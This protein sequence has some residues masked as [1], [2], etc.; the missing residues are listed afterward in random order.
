MNTCF[1]VLIISP[2]M[3]YDH[4]LFLK[5][6]YSDIK[7]HCTELNGYFLFQWL[8]EET[9]FRYF[10]IYSFLFVISF[11]TKEL[12]INV[13]VHI[14]VFYVGHPSVSLFLSIHCTPY[15]RNCPSPDNNFWYTGRKQWYL[16][17]IFF[18]FIK[19]WFFGFLGSKRAKDSP[20]WKAKVIYLWNSIAYDHDFWYSCV[21]GYLQLFF[22]LLFLMFL[23]VRGGCKRVDFLLYCIDFQKLLD[24]SSTSLSNFLQKK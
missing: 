22:F 11:W 5:R 10:V 16:Q 4:I 9:I 17:G 6:E 15:L 14:N 19:F 13:L 2:V 20:K 3:L 1:I 7:K 23:A 18:I 24:K 12:L 21:K 8:F